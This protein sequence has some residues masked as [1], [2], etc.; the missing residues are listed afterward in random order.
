M[1]RSVGLPRVVPPWDPPRGPRRTLGT[2]TRLRCLELA[3]FR[4]WRYL[5]DDAKLGAEVWKT[6]RVL[7][8]CS[9]W[10]CTQRPQV[11]DPSHVTD[12]MFVFFT[13]EKVLIDAL[14]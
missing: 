7:A 5:D 8:L 12:F 3:E 6:V 11:D 14:V 1:T 9:H 2:L 4:S 10:D 13:L